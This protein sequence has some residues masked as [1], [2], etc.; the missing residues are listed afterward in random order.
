MTKSSAPL[1]VIISGGGTGGHIFPAIAIANAIKTK[2]PDADILFVGA[3]GRMEMKKVPDA[4][5]PIVGLWISGLQRSLSLQNL[6]FPF[7]VISS[8]W[9]ANRILSRFKPQIAIG[10]GGY[11]SGALLQAA[12]W[13]NIPILI[14]EQNSYPGIT[15]KILARHARCICVAYEGLER[16]FPAEKICLLGN[17][18]RSSISNVALL[19]PLENKQLL[20]FRSDAPLLF[21]TG[22]SLGARALNEALAQ[23]L[24]TIRQYG[25]QLLWQCGEY[26]YEQYRHLETS[27]ADWLKIVPF[28][29]EM[30]QAYAAADFILSRAGALSIAEQQIVGKPL[31]LMPSPNVAE[32]H[33]TANAMALVAQQ[34]ALLLKDAEAIAQLPALLHQL[35]HNTE[36]AEHLSANLKKMAKTDAADKIATQAIFLVKN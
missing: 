4:G 21:A 34:A 8:L 13:R 17:P 11:A 16:F 15:N 6:S 31:I 5:Y 35:L 30:N 10:V 28:V 22:G 29:K 26:Y 7:K 9:K 24:P 2:V 1:K 18:V 14:Q 20:G 23:N 3:Q 36:M 12:V 32:D 27:H 25:L 33:Q 19:N